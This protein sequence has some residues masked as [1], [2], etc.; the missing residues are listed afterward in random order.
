MIGTQSLPVPHAPLAVGL[1]GSA[2]SHSMCMSGKTAFSHFPIPS[3]GVWGFAPMFKLGPCPSAPKC[4]ERR[5][6]R[7]HLR[8]WQ[9]NMSHVL[10]AHAP[11]SRT[12][13]FI[14][15]GGQVLPPCSPWPLALCSPSCCGL[16]ALYDGDPNFAAPAVLKI[17]LN[18]RRIGVII[19]RR[20]Q[21][22]GG[23]AL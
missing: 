7:P 9:P 11:S 14:K 22:L 17:Q 19:A 18:I 12:P 13:L 1:S 8:R 21:P 15:Q 3:E 23:N 10:P 20:R 2:C 5:I 16:S 4:W 6:Y